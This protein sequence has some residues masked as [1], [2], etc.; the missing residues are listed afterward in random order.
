MRDNSR[1]VLLKSSNSRIDQYP[2]F[3][4]QLHLQNKWVSH[5]IFFM[6]ICQSHRR[7]RRGK[8]NS[9]ACKEVCTEKSGCKQSCFWQGKKDVKIP[10]QEDPNESYQFVENGH[11]MSPL[12]HSHH[13]IRLTFRS[14]WGYIVYRFKIITRNSLISM[15]LFFLYKIFA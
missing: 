4:I 5:F 3:M 7:E 14:F 10:F 13:K 2:L 6:I 1:Q 15:I 11:P 9:L 12:K 8:H